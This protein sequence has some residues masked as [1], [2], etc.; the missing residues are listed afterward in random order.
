MNRY[1]HQFQYTMEKD[2]VTL[3]GTVD[4]GASGAVT[5]TKGGGIE[6]V[7]KEATA[8]QYTI[9]LAERY[10]RFLNIQAQ[11]ILATPSAVAAVQLLMDPATM[12]ADIKA[13]GQIVV[14]CLNY[15][16]VAANPESGAQLQLRIVMRNSSVGPND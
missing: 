11:P 10:S 8:G 6:S 4:I 3:F 16:G 14:Q 7:T 12:Q 15:A 13:D 2:T 5:L 1:L 9:Q